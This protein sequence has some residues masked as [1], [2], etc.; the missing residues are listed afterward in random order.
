MV[1][2]QC[3][4]SFDHLKLNATIDALLAAYRIDTNRIYVTGYSLGGNG[5]WLYG[6]NHAA[7]LAALVPIAG[8][9]PPSNSQPFSNLKNTVVWAIH[10]ADDDVVPTAWTTGTPTGA[11]PNCTGWMS[12]IAISRNGA[13]A[14][15]CL[16]SHP[17]HPKVAVLSNGGVGSLIGVTATRS[18]V[19]SMTAG[20]TWVAGAAPVAGAQ[21]Q[22]SIYA[23]GGHGGWDLTY[24]SGGVANAAF[25]GWL[26][27]QHLGAAA[28]TVPPVRP[29]R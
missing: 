2:P 26:L 19:Y 8:A 25:W 22:V 5:A 10:D 21:L 3:V 27:D 18:A 13:L 9:A 17:D 15:R 24:G 12:G 14:N 1:Q 6:L 20:W 7:R 28:V 23:D 16:D 11:A 4:T 29:P